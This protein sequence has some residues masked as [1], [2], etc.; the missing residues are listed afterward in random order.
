VKEVRDQKSEVSKSRRKTPSKNHC[1]A[2]GAM[3]LALCLPAEAQQPKKIPRIGYLSPQSPAKGLQQARLIGFQQGLRQLGYV[4]GQNIII[5]YRHAE[6]KLD[7]LPELA[8]ELVRFEVDVIVTMGDASITA[9]KQAT[10][11]IPIVVGVSGDLV[12]AGHVVSHARPGGNVTGLTDTSPELSTKRL[13][14]L[15]EFVPKASRVAVL[16]NPTNAV[17]VLNF[18]ETEIAAESLRLQIQ[19]LEVRNSKD[20][21]PAF[22]AIKKNRFGALLVFPDALL[23]FYE[24]RIVDFALKNRLPAIHAEQSF[25]DAGGLM[26]YG[27]SYP[28]MFRRA[29][30]YVDKLLN[31]AKAGD[32]PIER[33]SKFELVIN[34][35]TAK[36]IGLT[37][38]QSVLYRA[39]RVIK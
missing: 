11:T 35:N 8:A 39:D 5:E 36:Q 23:N 30:Y 4:E 26:S 13:E 32:L 33:P 27:P 12:G 7:R 15:K 6:G 37:I 22:S 28:D 25:V 17:M 21:V 3:L 34:L 9:A 2:L 31:G 14:L 1:L 24:P 38:P 16:W 19:S 20:F 18:K 10:S 29:A